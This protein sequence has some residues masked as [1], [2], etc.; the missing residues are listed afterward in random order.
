MAVSANA[1]EVFELGEIV[2]TEKKESVN[3]ITT[4]TEIT[5][6]DIKA[7][8]AQ[9][10]D[11]ALKLI[12]GVDVKKS[13][14]GQMFVFIRGFPQ[15]DVKVLIDGVPAY[16]TYFHTLDLS[17]FPVES[18]A[19]ITVVKG[20]SSVLYGAN[21]MGGVINII[22]KKGS[23]KLEASGSA[24][25]GDYNT[26]H[27]ALNHGWQ[28]G[29]INYFLTYAYQKSDGFRLSNNFDPNDPYVGI[30]SQFH[31]DGGK[32]DLSDY[33]KHG[34]NAKIGYD[35]EN[36]KL[37]L[38]FDYHHN[39]RG[40][41]TEYDRYWYFT[42]WEQW[43]LNLVGEKKF[44][45]NFTI[46]ARGFY[47]DHED[48]L[49]S[50]TD[51]TLTK[52][53]GSWWDKSA[54]DDYSAGVEVQANLK[55]AKFNLLKIGFNYIFEQHKERDYNRRD[56]RGNIT[57]YGWSEED[58]FETK[59]YTFAL[60]DEIYLGPVS[61]V[62]GLSYD[63]LEP[64]K[65]TKAPPRDNIDT[66]NPQIGIYWEL[67]KTT[68]LHTSIGKKTRFPHMKELYSEKGG[69][70]PNLK[71]QR[72]LTFEVGADKDLIWK[73]INGHFS[74]AYFYNRIKDLIDMIDTPSGPLYVNIG[75]ARI[76]GVEA[77]L[78]IMPLKNLWA[79]FNYTYL[80]TKDDEM[81]RPLEERPKHKFNL[82]IRY[83]FD[84]GLTINTQAT[85]C[86]KQYD[87]I[88]DKKTKTEITR[89]LPDY[90]IWNIKVSQEITKHSLLFAQV[91]NLTDVDYDEGNGPMPGRNFLVGVEFKF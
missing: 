61:I 91:T 12:P 89:R 5:S 39:R 73:N 35:Q 81:A 42:K 6:E 13:G 65:S 21:T 26:Q 75:K 20:A 74:I 31:E 53:G 67:N 45:E 77:D 17:Q 4:V 44:G 32:R 86:H 56:K 87:Y 62:A 64:V 48:T 41:P 59:T 72:A 2:V 14:K 40:I 46:K 58:I 84:F 19:K 34:L 88:Y 63:R 30:N 7:R 29:K 51:K 68:S 52:L 37:Y 28:V 22:T 69:G 23:P 38:S 66:I 54:Y 82:D 55:I 43:H 50:Y 10:L 85:Y 70:N 15:E 27:Y 36:T 18:I 24:A 25:F 16:E 78:L 80:W 9:T 57:I 90:F 49:N 76:Q 1:E 47:V 3:K 33:E 83:K 11:E 79:E 60:E 8:G 71:E